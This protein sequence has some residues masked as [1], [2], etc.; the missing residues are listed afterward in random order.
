M[1]HDIKHGIPGW[2]NFVALAVAE[3]RCSQPCRHHMKK[4][5]DATM[6]M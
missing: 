5:T 6:A 3:G 1:I 2:D 4:K